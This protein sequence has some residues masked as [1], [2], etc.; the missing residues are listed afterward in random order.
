MPVRRALI[1]GGGGFMGANLVAGFTAA[2]W[3]VHTTLRP[4]GSDWRRPALMGAQIHE[5]ELGDFEAVRG[6][7][8]RTRPELVVHAAFASAYARHPL[9]RLLADGPVI[10]ANLIDALGGGVPVRFVHLGSSMEYGSSDRPH[11]EED[12]LRPTSS[13]GAVKAAESQLVLERSRSGAI[14]AV[15]LRI[16]SVFGPWESPHRLV[17]TAIR[18][19]LHGEEMP[20]TPPGLRRDFV[21]VADVVDA[22]IRAAAATAAVG[23]VVNIGTGCQ[24]SNEAMVAEI[25]RVVGRPIRIARSAYEPHATDRPTWLAD[26][27][28]AKRLLGWEPGHDLAEGIRKAVEWTR[29]QPR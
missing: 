17:P 27:S 29:R 12:P 2:G 24:S 7:V 19:A 22:C 18:A 13:R 16:F 23:E 9:R 1:T 11:R 14:D 10:L 6:L 3:E 28:K 25:A 20:L 21:F 15:V 8:D 4:G 26:P 5:L